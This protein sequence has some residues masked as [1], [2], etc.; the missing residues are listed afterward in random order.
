MKTKQMMWV[1]VMALAL[2]MSAAPLAA[3]EQTQGPKTPVVKVPYTTEEAKAVVLLLSS[4]HEQPAKATYEAASVQVRQI[5]LDVASDAQAFTLHRA[6]ALDALGR[7]WKDA[8]GLALSATLLARKDTPEGMRHRLI[9]SSAIHYGKDARAMI[10]PYLEDK[11]PYLRETAKEAFK[12][13][14]WIE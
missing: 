3:Q 8:R 9:M 6:R 14:V 11:D 10:A 2:V 12:H 7:H 1:G 13:M 5:L 4:H